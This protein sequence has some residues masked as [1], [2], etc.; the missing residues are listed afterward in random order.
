MKRPLPT[1][2]LGKFGALTL[3][4]SNKVIAWRGMLSE[5]R[6]DRAIEFEVAEAMIGSGEDAKLVLQKC[7][8]RLPIIIPK[9]YNHVWKC[10]SNLP[11]VESK[12]QLFEWYSLIALSV[13][14]E[15]EI[16]VTLEPGDV[17]SIFNFFLR[18]TV[19][20]EEITWSNINPE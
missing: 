9:L 17:P 6:N 12:E 3:Y 18:F 11:D 10:F 14:S 8:N 13:K 7:T 16:W 19:N 2:D 20:G 4:E 1:Y 5:I 15:S